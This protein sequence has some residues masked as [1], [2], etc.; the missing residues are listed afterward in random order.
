MV[1]WEMILGEQPHLFGLAIPL[2]SIAGRLCGAQ[3]SRFS[4]VHV[5]WKYVY[6]LS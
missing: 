3:E 6:S 2:C 5:D 1:I 4:P